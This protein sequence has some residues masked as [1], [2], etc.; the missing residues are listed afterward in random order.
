MNQHSLQLKADGHDTLLPVKAVPNASRSRIV[1]LWDGRLK[2]AIATPPE[3][4]KAN[5]AIAELLAE[6]LSIPKNRV[7]LES[8]PASPRKVFRIHDLLP[9]VVWAALGSVM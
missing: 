9:E 7:T 4:G 8:K 3:K 5:K 1:G 2:I 6:T